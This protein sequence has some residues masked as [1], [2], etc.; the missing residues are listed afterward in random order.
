MYNLNEME[1]LVRKLPPERFSQISNQDNLTFIHLIEKLQKEGKIIPIDPEIVMGIHRCLS[2]LP[3][4][5]QEV[6][7][8]CF[9]K[10]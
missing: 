7:L 9:P 2:L 10:R 1:Q 6:G 4:L 3:L 5:Q 8:T